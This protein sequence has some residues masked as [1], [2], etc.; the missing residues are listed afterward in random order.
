MEEMV[1]MQS[2][3]LY[4]DGIP[5]SQLWLVLLYCQFEG[6]VLFLVSLIFKFAL[7]CLFLRLL[8]NLKQEKLNKNNYTFFVKRVF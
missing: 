5:N 4:F 7:N 3:T 2:R 8:E 1:G 6:D